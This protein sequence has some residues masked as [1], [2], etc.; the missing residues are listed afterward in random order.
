[1][2][3]MDLKYRIIYGYESDQE[4][5]IGPDELEKAYGLFLFGGRAIFKNGDAID[6]KHIQAIKP[7][8]NEMLGW[9]KEHVL[10][11]YDESD[12][13]KL[14]IRKAAQIAQGRAKERVEYLIAH[15]KTELI[16]KNAD[17]HEL[18]RENNPTSPLTK[19]LADK[20]S[21]NAK[22]RTEA[23]EESNSQTRKSANTLHPDL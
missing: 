16:G 20:M 12:L 11:G 23:Q 7:D 3:N 2:A 8:Y 1:M 13:D 5:S 10:D 9:D 21:I 14:G 19:Q 17:I 6:S 18:A 15:G 4:I 22:T